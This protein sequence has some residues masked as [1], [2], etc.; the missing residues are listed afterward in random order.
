LLNSPL[1]QIRWTK[2]GGPLPQERVSQNNYGKSLVIKHVNFED[3]GTYSCE[4]SNGVGSAKSYSISLQVQGKT[5]VRCFFLRVYIKHFT[6]APYF[7]VEPE[8]V[9]AAEDETI[10]FKCEAKGVPKPSIQWIYN[11][12]PIDRAPQNARRKVQANKIIIS[13]LV[14]ADTGN[15]GCNATNS[16]GYVYKDV[17]V[18][19]LGMHTKIVFIVINL[20]S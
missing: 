10:E 18:N 8:I 4:A 17:Y 3:E 1:P 11:G 7:T 13:Q 16:I 5:I 2:L 6:A 12:L 9:N 14:K 19:V 15:Y 20:T